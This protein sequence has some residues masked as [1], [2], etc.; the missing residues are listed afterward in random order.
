VKE[1]ASTS[2]CE[3]YGERAP[4]APSLTQRG[5]FA[6]TVLV[7]VIVLRNTGSPSEPTL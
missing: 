7:G 2:G 1:C 6:L 5:Y 4:D 3:A